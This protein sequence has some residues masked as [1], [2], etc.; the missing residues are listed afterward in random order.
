MPKASYPTSLVVNGFLLFVEHPGIGF[1][2]FSAAIAAYLN[3][4]FTYS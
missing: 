3:Q 2:S 4:L 1:Q